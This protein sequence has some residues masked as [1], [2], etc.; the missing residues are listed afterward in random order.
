MDCD[1]LVGAGE[2]R[3]CK[4]IV[5]SYS[6]ILHEVFTN[7]TNETVPRDHPACLRKQATG[8]GA[9]RRKAGT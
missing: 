7:T 2:R 1:P 6:P 4:R 8:K 3:M 5:N 9:A